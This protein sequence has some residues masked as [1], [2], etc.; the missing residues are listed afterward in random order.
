[1]DFRQKRCAYVAHP[2][3]Q[4]I[5]TPLPP[6]ASPCRHLSSMQACLRVKG[7]ATLPSRPSIVGRRAERCAGR[8][9]DSHQQEDGHGPPA[10][11]AG[12]MPS[13]DAVKAG[14]ATYASPLAQS[15]VPGMVVCL[16]SLVKMDTP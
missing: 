16:S 15:I 8:G 6:P 13:K 4:P 5:G 2:P 14:F 1:M 10:R 12:S 11:C 3:A 9:E 7:L